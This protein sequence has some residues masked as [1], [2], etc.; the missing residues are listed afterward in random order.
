[1]VGFQPRLGFS[2]TAPDIHQMDTKTME[3]YKYPPQGQSSEQIAGL[4]KEKC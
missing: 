4:S 3:I 1:M 2:E